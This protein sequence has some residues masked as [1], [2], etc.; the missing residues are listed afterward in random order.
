M[1]WRWSKQL[2]RWLDPQRK[3]LELIAAT[4][5]RSALFRWV[6]GVVLL[7]RSLLSLGCDLHGARTARNGKLPAD[8]F[9]S[10][11]R[12]PD[13]QSPVIGRDWIGDVN[14]HFPSEVFAGRFERVTDFA[15]GKRQQDNVRLP[16]KRG[17]SRT[18]R[19]VRPSAQPSWRVFGYQRSRL[20]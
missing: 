10:W 19:R 2:D 16:N 1:P 8:L 14:K 15:E 12:M 6:N 17:G 4:A 7:W 3:I 20:R 11:M 5:F 9:R 13:R 18:L